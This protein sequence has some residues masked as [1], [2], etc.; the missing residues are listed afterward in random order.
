MDCECQKA[1]GLSFSQNFSVYHGLPSKLAH[2]D[3][4]GEKSTV[5]VHGGGLAGHGPA[6]RDFFSLGV[7]GFAANTQ[8]KR[9]FSGPDGPR[10]PLGQTPERL[11]STMLAQAKIL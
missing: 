1:L 8:R 9:R 4:Q 5:T 6:K 2:C 3:T 10:S 11:Q 7:G